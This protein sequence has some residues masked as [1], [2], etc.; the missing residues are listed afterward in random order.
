MA[1]FNASLESWVAWRGSRMPAARFVPLAILLAWAAS[2]AGATDV[3]RVLCTIAVAYTLVAQFRL[4]DDIADRERDA[5]DHP[6]RVV[7]AGPLI[8]ASMVLAVFNAAALGVLNGWTYAIAV[9][10][11]SALVLAWYRVHRS[12]GLVHAHVL[13]LKY[14]AFVALLAAPSAHAPALALGAA[15]VYG[16]L[17]GFELLDDPALRAATWTRARRI[18]APARLRY[19]PFLIAAAGLVFITVREMS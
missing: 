8:T 10:V 11:L 19:V 2:A 13:L 1:T 6:Q 4:W 17:V 12:R 5:R 14:P 3:V 15:L 7:N 18:E 9:L 16:A